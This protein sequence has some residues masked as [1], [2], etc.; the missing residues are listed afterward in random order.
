MFNGSLEAICLHILLFGLVHSY[1]KLPTTPTESRMNNV[2]SGG[3]ALN[4]MALFAPPPATGWGY[5]QSIDVTKGTYKS[6]HGLC[7]STWFQK[8]KMRMF[9]GTTRNK[10]LLGAPGIATRSKD[11]TRGSW[12]CY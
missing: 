10:K 11:A 3:N 1:P 2:F 6:V 7:M 5:T 8:E 4:N 9:F 12:P